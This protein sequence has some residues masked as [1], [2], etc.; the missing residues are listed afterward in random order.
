MPQ[1]TLLHLRREGTSTLRLAASRDADL[2]DGLD[3]GDQATATIGRY[4]PSTDDRTL[5]ITVTD[6]PRAGKSGWVFSMDAH[7]DDGDPIGFFAFSLLNQGQAIPDS[8]VYHEPSAEDPNE[9]FTKVALDQKFARGLRFPLTLNELQKKL[10]S[11]GKLDDPG[12]SPE[13]RSHN[14]RW[15]NMEDDGSGDGSYGDFGI[16]D[17]KITYIWIQTHN[18]ENIVRTKSGQFYMVGRGGKTVPTP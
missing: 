15:I 9:P 12:P 18:D 5:F 16:R 11:K 4:D 3:L 7:G 6:G 13:E 10:G 2:D 14:Y 17:G 8:Y 1:G